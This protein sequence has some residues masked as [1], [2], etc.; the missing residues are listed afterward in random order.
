MKVK[1]IVGG[2]VCALMLMPAFG[3]GR[4]SGYGN[5]RGQGDNGENRDMYP[6][7]DDKLAEGFSSNWRINRF[8]AN[9]D[10]DVAEDI[11]EKRTAYHKTMRGT[12]DLNMKMEPIIKPFSTIDEIY[13]TSEFT[14]TIMFPPDYT[15]VGAI[16]SAKM[17]LNK[18]S[19]NTLYILPSRDFIEGSLTVSLT[20][21][22]QNIVMNIILRRYMNSMANGGD[23]E[24]KYAN[25]KQFVSTMIVYRDIPNVDVR[26][27]LETYYALK[28]PS[29]RNNFDEDGN[30]D[31]FT[32]DGIPY[33]VIRDDKFGEIEW[34]G[35]NYKISHK[36]VEHGE[37]VDMRMQ[38]HFNP[39]EYK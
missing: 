23:Y 17:P 18:F 15:V 16:S 8:K 12:Y 6:I 14:T 31:V 2:V 28:G 27:I 13:I 9:L 4:D 26:T 1:M 20:S 29:A 7:D 22:D 10:R 36:Y 5:S 38:R 30:Y 11:R 3:A 24:I 34:D 35:I 21:G 19:S 37:D 33:Y 32:Y 39:G 25:D